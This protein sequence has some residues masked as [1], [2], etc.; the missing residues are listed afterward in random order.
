MSKRILIASLHVIALIFPI[1]LG[2]RQLLINLRKPQPLNHNGGLVIIIV[3]LYLAELILIFVV[4][5]K[6]FAPK[7]KIYKN[8]ITRFIIPILTNKEGEFIPFSKM[9]SFSISEDKEN[10]SIMLHGRDSSLLW[11]SNNTTHILPIINALR[12]NNIPEIN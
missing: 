6:L 2:I 9:K 1:Y 3:V 11:A 12:R 8:G 4:I 5:E 7:L 10:C